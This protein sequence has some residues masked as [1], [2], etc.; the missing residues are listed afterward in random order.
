MLDW[1][2]KKITFALY[3]YVLVAKI[4]RNGAKSQC[5]KTGFK[6]FRDLNNFRQAVESPKS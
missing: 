2:F 3:T 5:T 4:L 1:S 6:I